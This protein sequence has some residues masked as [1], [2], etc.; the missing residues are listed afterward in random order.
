MTPVAWPRTSSIYSWFW[1]KRSGLLCYA[2]Y[3]AAGLWLATQLGAITAGRLLR[4]VRHP[5][6]A[7]LVPT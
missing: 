4:P 7:Q 1:V 5:H 6:L 3:R 2:M